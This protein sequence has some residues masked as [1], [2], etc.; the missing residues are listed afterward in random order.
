MKRILLAATLLI[1]LGC[2]AQFVNTTTL[3]EYI[4]QHVRNS[5]VTA[6]QELR[7]NRILTGLANHIDSAK[8]GTSGSVGVDT[9]YMQN[10]STLRYKKNGVWFS[11]VI[12]GGGGGVSDLFAALAAG[13]GASTNYT[14]AFNGRLWTLDSARVKISSLKTEPGAYL[15]DVDRNKDGNN[16]ALARFRAGTL[17]E[18][19]MVVNSAAGNPGFVGHGYYSDGGTSPTHRMAIGLDVQYTKGYIDMKNGWGLAFEKNGAAYHYFNTDGSW[20]F[21]FANAANGGVGFGLGTGIFPDS[22]VN[23]Q[24]GGNTTTRSALVL[25]PGPLRSTP[26]NFSLE[27]D[28]LPG[29]TLWWTD[30]SGTRRRVAPFAFTGGALE[31]SG[32]V[33]VGGST[34]A[35]APSW[36]ERH[37]VLGGLNLHENASSAT[38]KHNTRLSSAT[39]TFNYL[40]NGSVS[41]MGLAFTDT[42]SMASFGWDPVFNYMY[43]RVVPLT[44]GIAYQS[45]GPTTH[46]GLNMDGAAYFGVTGSNSGVRIGN[47]SSVPQAYLDI[48]G[49]STTKPSISLPQSLITTPVIGSLERHTNDGLYWTNAS[50]RVRLDS[51]WGGVG[52]GGSGMYLIN[53]IVEDSLLRLYDDSTLMVKAPIDGPGYTVTSTDST[54]QILLS[55]N[56]LTPYDF[57]AVNDSTVDNSAAFTALWA[58]VGYKPI[59]IP[60]GV[61]TIPNTRLTIPR[62]NG[63]IFGAGIGA[64]VLRTNYINNTGGTPLSNIDGFIYGDTAMSGLTMHD[65]TIRHYGSS[66]SKYVNQALIVSYMGLNYAANPG[67]THITEDLNFYNLKFEAP[68]VSFHAMKLFAFRSGAGGFLRRVRGDNLFGEGIGSN[69][70]DLSSGGSGDHLEQKWLSDVHFTRVTANN[71]GTVGDYGF[72]ATIE[73]CDNCNLD[74]WKV[75]G[76][77]NIAFEFIKTKNSTLSNSTIKGSKASTLA[78]A[79]NGFATHLGDENAVLNVIVSDTNSLGIQVQNQNYFKMDNS[80]FTNNDLIKISGVQNSTFSNSVFDHRGTTGHTVLSIEGGSK[81]NLFTNITVRGDSATAGAFSTGILF[82]GATTTGNLVQGANIRYGSGGGTPVSESASAS[83][84]QVVNYSVNG[85]RFNHSG[86]WSET[87]RLQKIGSYYI[88]FDGSGRLRHKS[89]IPTGDTDGTVLVPIPSGGTTDQV[90]AKTNNTDYNLYWKTDAT[91]GG[92]GTVTSFTFTDG[93]GLDGT[94]TNPNTTPT[95]SIAPSFTGMVKSNGS[96]FLAA[97]AGTDYSLISGLTDDYVP[98]ASGT[99]TIENST[100]RHNASGEVGINQAPTAGRK[101]AVTGTVDFTGLVYTKGSSA[102]FHIQQRGALANAWEIYSP[103]TTGDLHF[104]DYKATSGDRFKIAGGSAGTV[105]FLGTTYVTGGGT[106][107]LVI[108]KTTGAIGTQAISGGGDLTTAS[109]GLTET[110]DNITLGGTLTGT[111]AIT[112][113][114]ALQLGTNASKLGTLDIYATTGVH[115]QSDAVLSLAGQ[116][117]YET[118]VA[119]DA[120]F[121]WTNTTPDPGVVILPIITADRT[122]TLPTNT[123]GVTLEIHNENTANFNWSFIGGTVMDAQNNTVTLIPNL[124]TIR[125]QADGTKWKIVST[126]SMEYINTI[127]SDF[128]LTAA[129][130]VQSAFPTAQDVLTVV[131]STSYEFEGQYIINTGATTHTTA[132][133]FALAGGASVTSFE[134]VAETHSAAANTVTQATTSA[135]WWVTHVSGVASKVINATNTAVYTIIKFKGIARMNAGGTITPQINFSANPTGT[136]L[137]KVGSYI[138]FKPIGNSSVKAVGPWG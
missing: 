50:G 95:L 98:V 105:S 119:T 87:A 107:M 26:K 51:A 74:G 9:I 135:L 138:K 7:M 33:T 116:I 110:G 93:N 106:E 126:S 91:G 79:F 76:A 94:V 78:I 6:F 48:A 53:P 92:G 63:H 99:G 122:V 64:T 62:R 103:G 113:A 124:A 46:H 71:L 127:Q 67:G 123:A 89:S 81:N 39:L 88:W 111:T 18:V 97:V 130:G 120:N 30:S 21:N 137:M 58:N 109:N 61:W 42:G 2:S 10:D 59:Y 129:S 22:D 35:T 121:T 70:L 31:T 17:G 83:G 108:D 85:T 56:Y 14:S 133:A 72:G 68:N 100:I 34:Q 52:G 77:K 12:P 28:N 128:T 11:F 29:S 38:S 118:E 23:A 32:V 16:G 3:R 114:Q 132:L 37:M 104:F 75:N 134:Y 36:G 40:A 20:S 66:A 24:F 15:L 101:L 4:N 102:G 5:P 136:N 84:N 25:R 86:T 1:T 69:F 43:Q 55:G 49:T 44:S 80:S 54:F 47:Q 117:K 125:L 73:V 45:P 19:H 131:G 13:G 57:G 96:A 41:Q 27:A 60:A 90:L 112:G 115:I 65:F 82:S 8:L